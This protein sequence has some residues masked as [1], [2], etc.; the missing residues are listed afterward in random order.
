MSLFPLYDSSRDY[1]KMSA[2]AAVWR[3]TS[4]ERNRQAKTALIAQLKG[5]TK[6][7]KQDSPKKGGIADVLNTSA[8][9]ALYAL[10]SGR[11]FKEACSDFDLNDKESVR[12]W[13]QR[14]L[15]AD[16]LKKDEIRPLGSGGA[17]RTNALNDLTRMYM[18]ETKTRQAT[19]GSWISADYME[20]RFA[21]RCDIFIMYLQD[22]PQTGGVA[23]IL[24]LEDLCRLYT[25]DTGVTFEKVCNTL[26]VDNEAS[27]RRWQRHPALAHVD[28]D[29][30]N[31]LGR[32][33]T[34]KAMERFRDTA[35]AKEAADK[36]FNAKENALLRA[37]DIRIPR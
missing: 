6:M 24:D 14:L 17:G 35:I 23:D 8:L 15:D 32:D 20:E 27:I 29:A 5:M 19:A 18:R 4:E 28:F 1:R 9:F 26:D 37:L 11:T 13:K 25:F 21:K 16:I 33:K 31:G 30:P 3:D 34:I 2:T 22:S 10:D 36:P 7:L 12:N